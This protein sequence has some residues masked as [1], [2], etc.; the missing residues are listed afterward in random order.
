MKPPI[1]SVRRARRIA[2]FAADIELLRNIVATVSGRLEALELEMR[3]LARPRHHGLT[4]DALTILRK[5]PEPMPIRAITLLL[6]EARGHDRTDARLVK[7]MTDRMRLLLWRQE[8]AGVVRK[9]VGKGAD[10]R[11]VWSITQ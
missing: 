11:Q 4:R 2:A 7:R 3:A 10:E 6:M 8:Q 1:V 5:A 9:A